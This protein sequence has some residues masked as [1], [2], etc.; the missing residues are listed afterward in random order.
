MTLGNSAEAKNMTVGNQS[1]AQ[2]AQ[3]L[4][5]YAYPL[6]IMKISRDL[7]L[8]S[9]L[10][11]KS[12][13]NHL[14]LFKQLAQPE[15][16]AVVLGNRDTLYTVAWIDLSKGPVAF[17]IPEMGDRYYVMPLLDAWTNT[18]QSL[19][20][21]TTG[22]DAQQYILYR[23]GDAKPTVP[24]YESIEAPTSMVWLTGRIEVQGDDDLGAAQ[25]IQSKFEMT[26]FGEALTGTDPFGAVEPTFIGS[27]IGLPVPYSLQMSPEEYYNTF[28][29]ML[30]TN[31]P[32]NADQTFVEAVSEKLFDM[33]TLNV[34]S[35]I[36]SSVQ[37][38]LGAGLKHQQD[39]LQATFAEGSAQETPWIL[40]KEAMGTW[41]V[42]YS[43][44]AYW[45][46][47]GLGANLVEDAVYGVTQ[48]DADLQQLS[49]EHRY[50]ICFEAGDI[51]E[52]RGFWS[53]TAYNIDGYLEENSLKRYQVG[54]NFDIQ[55]DDNGS[56]RIVLSS[57]RSDDINEE[58]WLPIP[59]GDFKLLF[60]MYWPE[61]SVLAPSYA[62]PPIARIT[63]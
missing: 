20:S 62:L 22:Q 19:G 26:S 24:G 52:V 39:Y 31:P 44:R 58:N 23:K 16:T 63:L 28:F 8:N 43:T 56:L 15:N 34:F 60:R 7:M 5:E 40:N 30:R 9:Q 18:F 12:N 33:G 17:S 36:E 57:D 25:D 3:T 4:A 11:Q 61:P 29:Q 47:W 2:L 48:L 55:T 51:P 21:R 54:Q 49:G 32:L 6:V 53:L 35:D 14:I 46:V 13:D 50:E 10:R 59:T 45:A 1:S 27:H 37:E 41:G 42:G 38:I